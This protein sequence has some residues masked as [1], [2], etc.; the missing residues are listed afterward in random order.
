M[1][2]SIVTIQKLRVPDRDVA[3][4]VLRAQMA[5]PAA[6]EALRNLNAGVGQ[7]AHVRKMP[8]LYRRLQRSENPSRR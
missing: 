3:V 4:R 1:N 5:S 8:D 6:L 7:T 2:T